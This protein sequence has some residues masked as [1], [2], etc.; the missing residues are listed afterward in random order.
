MPQISI[1]E[2]IDP[3]TGDKN[4]KYPRQSRGY[5]LFGR[6][7]MLPATPHAALVR[8]AICIGRPIHTGISPSPF[9]SHIAAILNLYTFSFA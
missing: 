8:L 3:F 4:K 6:S 7:P 9:P 2:Y 1:K 5:F